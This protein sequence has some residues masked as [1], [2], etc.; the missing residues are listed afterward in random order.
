M[1]VSLEATVETHAAAPD[2][3]RQAGRMAFQNAL[4]RRRSPPDAAAV[5]VDWPSVAGFLPHATTATKSNRRL[6][7]MLIPAPRTAR[8]Y[9][10]NESIRHGVGFVGAIIG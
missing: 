6:A 8:D 3:V 2:Q 1:A 7:P 4:K 10:A 9:Y 5:G